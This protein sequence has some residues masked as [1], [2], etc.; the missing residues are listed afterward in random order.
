MARKEKDITTQRLHLRIAGWV[1]DNWTERFEG[2]TVRFADDG[3]T[4]I[5]GDLKDQSALF[6]LLRTIENGGMKLI[7]CFAYPGGLS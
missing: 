3:S 6:G 1:P 2:I 4:V 7:A 5:C